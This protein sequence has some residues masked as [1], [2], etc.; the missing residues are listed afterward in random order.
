ML[1]RRLRRLS[2]S[3]FKL[4]LRPSQKHRYQS[5]THNTIAVVIPITPFDF[6][7]DAIVNVQMNVGQQALV[8]F[9][10]L[11]QKGVMH[12]LKEHGGSEQYLKM[13]FPSTEAKRAWADYL[14]SYFRYRIDCESN[15][16]QEKL[17]SR[18]LMIYLVYLLLRDWLGDYEQ[19]QGRPTEDAGTEAGE[20]WG[21]VC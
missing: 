8:A 1:A 18:P 13:K 19:D 21:V 5:Y 3:I 14:F 4:D 10:D 11:L 7:E 15:P 12:T 9:K 2:H 20:L 16:N 17:L 6:L